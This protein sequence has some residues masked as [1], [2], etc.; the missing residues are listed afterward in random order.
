MCTTWFEFVHAVHAANSTKFVQVFS[1]GSVRQRCAASDVW[2][3]WRM[4]ESCITT[5]TRSPA[6]PLFFFFFFFFLTRACTKQFDTTIIGL[7]M[8]MPYT[9]MHMQSH[10]SRVKTR[11]LRLREALHGY[12]GHLRNVVAQLCIYPIVKHFASHYL[13]SRL[14]FVVSATD[15]SE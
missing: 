7:L 2:Y 14:G 5:C 9:Y 6:P 10:C 3:T 12:C 15:V 1:R 13:N 8:C 11:I 4:E